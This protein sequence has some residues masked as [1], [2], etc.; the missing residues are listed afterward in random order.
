MADMENTVAYGEEAARILAPIQDTI[1]GLSGTFVELFYN[2]LSKTTRA[3]KILAQLSTDETHH[4]KHNQATYLTAILAPDVTEENHRKKAGWIGQIHTC[5]GIDILSLIEAFRVYQNGLYGIILTALPDSMAREQIMRIISQRI[6]VELSAQAELFQRFDNEIA[7]AF[8]RIDQHAIKEAN[9]RD[10][11]RGVLDVFASLESS[12]SAFFGRADT[13]G[14]LQIEASVGA[15]AERY[16]RAMEAG[17]VPKIRIDPAD[18]AGQGPG[19]RAWRNGQIVATDN[20]AVE[21]ELEPWRAVGR[22]LGFRSS[23]AV[24]IPDESGRSIGLLSLYSSWPGYFS[25]PQIRGLLTHTQG[26]LGAA[27]QKRERLTVIPWREQAQHRQYIHDGQL[28]MLYQPI[29]DLRT[30]VLVKVEALA[31]LA[32]PTGELIVPYRFLASLGDAEL[33]KL[34]EIGLQKASEDRHY[35]DNLGPPVTIAINFPAEAWGDARYEAVLFDTLHATGVP[36]D[37]LQLE[38]LETHDTRI[39]DAQRFHQRLRDAGIRTAQDDLGSGH[40]SLLRMNQYLFDEVKIDQALVSNAIHKPKRALEFILYISHLAHAFDTPVTVEG[41]EHLAMIEAAAI[42]GA[43]HGQG[44]GIA[45]PM[46]AKTIPSWHKTYVYPFTSVQH[47]TTALGALAGFLLW[48]Q[49]LSAIAHQP[50]LV[51]IFVRSENALDHFLVTHNLQDSPLGALVFRNRDAAARHHS[52]YEQSRS[53]IIAS[54]TRYWQNESAQ[55]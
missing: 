36:P 21:S 7:D 46:P 29:I 31:R 19:G 32:S 52:I 25:T 12:L 39:H 20:W 6:M 53:D 48:D 41:L 17:I 42:L 54:L 47:P 8:M 40:S 2:A 45:R 28:V 43:D 10:I 30:G 11:V 1:Q 51:E 13:H 27:L 49:R 22:A 44:Y 14:E 3:A 50:N 9:L 5:I 37:R 4:L 15:S 55:P 38:M 16:H 26:V 33:L 18:P 24:P 35:F 34:F 23:A